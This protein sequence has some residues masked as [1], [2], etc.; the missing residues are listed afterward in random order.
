VK[1]IQ[2]CTCAAQPTAQFS[3]TAAASRSTIGKRSVLAAEQAFA[4]PWHMASLE[5][6]GRWLMGHGENM[7]GGDDE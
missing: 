6:G 3:P 4:V 7:E 2:A 5:S 1:S